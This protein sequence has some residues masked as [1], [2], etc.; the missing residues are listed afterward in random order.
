[1]FKNCHILSTQAIAALLACLAV[2]A[3]TQQGTGH[4]YMIYRSTDSCVGV[5]R[6][7]HSPGI[8]WV[9][10]GHIKEPVAWLCSLVYG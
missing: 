2:W 5:Y 10:K 9:L 1:M 4:Y 6:G 3:V 8:D 7:L